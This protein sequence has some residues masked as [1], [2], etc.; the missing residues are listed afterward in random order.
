MHHR[1]IDEGCQLG[2]AADDVL[3]FTADALP[4]RIERRH[5]GILGMDLMYGHGCS[6]WAVVRD[7]NTPGGPLSVRQGALPAGRPASGKWR[8]ISLIQ[9]IS[10]LPRPTIC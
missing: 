6:R 7:Y 3:R 8:A 4:D 10:R 1:R 5:S 9:A 2:L